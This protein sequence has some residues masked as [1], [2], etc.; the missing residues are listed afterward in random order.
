M[1]EQCICSFCDKVFVRTDDADEYKRECFEHE[2]NEH[3]NGKEYFKDLIE[4]SIEELNSEYNVEA[5]YK[6]FGF[7][8]Y[9]TDYG[10]GEDQIGMSFVLV[11]SEDKQVAINYEFKYVEGEFSLD[12]KGII[13]KLT[14][15]Y[16][17]SVKKEYKG[18]LGF[19]DWCGGH[20]EDD[21]TLNGM[22]L[23]DILRELKG[24]KIEIRVLDEE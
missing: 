11:L 17:A 22:Y 18:V 14:P 23:R 2:V 13:E 19:E 15:Q 16:L 3:M 1:K 7:R 9:Y 20:G 8:P 4:E 21:Y 6:R 24:K 10:Y 12:K 5:R